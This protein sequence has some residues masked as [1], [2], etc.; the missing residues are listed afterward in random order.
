MFVYTDHKG[1]IAWEEHGLN[2]QGKGVFSTEFFVLQQD[3]FTGSV[4]AEV[5]LEDKVFGNLW[6]D[7][8]NL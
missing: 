4:K 5:G 6:T 2:S 3:N 1:Q 7:T 8:V